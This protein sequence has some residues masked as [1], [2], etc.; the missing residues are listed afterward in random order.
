LDII[1]SIFLGYLNAL[2]ARRKGQKPFKWALFTFLA[3]LFFEVMSGTFVLM[4]FYKGAMTPTAVSE[5]LFN[6]PIHTVFMWACG[7]GGYLLIRYRI[8]KLG[9]QQRNDEL[10][11]Q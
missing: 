6:H 3:F 2:R 9:D 1:L 8:D 7:L 5:Y 11:P 10:P 4:A